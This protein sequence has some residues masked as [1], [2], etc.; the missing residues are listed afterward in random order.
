V[1]VIAMN[2]KSSGHGA[3]LSHARQS[4]DMFLTKPFH[5][6]ELLAFTKR[7]VG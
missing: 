5:P 7:L 4:V 3:V 1:K 6:L 2:A